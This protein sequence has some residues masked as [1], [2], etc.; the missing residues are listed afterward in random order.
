MRHV[1]QETSCE[2]CDNQH[3]RGVGQRKNLASPIGFGDLNNGGRGNLSILSILARFILG[4]SFRTRAVVLFSS[5][6][7]AGSERVQLCTLMVKGVG[8]ASSPSCALSNYCVSIGKYPRPRHVDY[9]SRLLYSFNELIEFTV[10]ENCS[11]S[12]FYTR[13]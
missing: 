12:Y 1:K 6:P 8:F 10:I 9:H 2:R 7:R 3:V 11:Y 4:Q 13:G 5:A